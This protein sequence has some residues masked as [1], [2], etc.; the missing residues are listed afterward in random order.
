MSAVCLPNNVTCLSTRVKQMIMR[1]FANNLIETDVSAEEAVINDTIYDKLAASIVVDSTTKKTLKRYELYEKSDS[2]F[3]IVTLHNH[4]GQDN[5]AYESIVFASIDNVIA[6]YNSNTATKIPTSFIRFPSTSYKSV[7]Y[8]VF[9]HKDKTGIFTINVKAIGHDDEEVVGTYFIDTS[10]QTISVS[11]SLFKVDPYLVWEDDEE[12]G[13]EEVP[14]EGTEDT[15]D[16]P[17]EDG[18]STGIEGSQT[19]AE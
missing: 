6:A 17:V 9:A 16:E 15:V 11:E 5:I 18:T 10:T 1:E 7:S 19:G 12:T 8:E 14:E 4:V 3:I 2:Q 13:S